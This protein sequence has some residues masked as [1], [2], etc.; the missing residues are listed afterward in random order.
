MNRGKCKAA[1]KQIKSDIEELDK[2]AE[3]ADVTSFSNNAKKALT[4][5]EATLSAAKF[6][7]AEKAASTSSAALADA[8]KAAAAAAPEPEA[9]ESESED[10]E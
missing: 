10:S 7:D 3:D 9:E 6:A 5:A 8:K 4:A 1:I 2:L